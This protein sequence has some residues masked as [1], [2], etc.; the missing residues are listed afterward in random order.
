MLEKELENTGTQTQK[1]LEEKEKAADARQ[2]HGS[3]PLLLL[4]YSSHHRAVLWR[5][6]LFKFNLFNGVQPFSM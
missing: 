3:N 6:F 5:L 2:S 4:E 1:M